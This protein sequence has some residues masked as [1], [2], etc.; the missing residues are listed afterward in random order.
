MPLGILSSKKDHIIAVVMNIS[1]RLLFEVLFDCPTANFGPP[2]G[3]VGGSLTT[4]MLITDVHDF[5]LLHF[6]LSEIF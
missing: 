1:M 2:L 5:Y 4:S 6:C 3:V